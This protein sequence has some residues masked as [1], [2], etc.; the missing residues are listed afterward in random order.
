MDVED[1]VMISIDDHTVEPPDMFERTMPAK[2]R[3]RAPRLVRDE[4]GHDRWL[5][6]GNPVG[7]P[8]VSAVVSWP[9]EEWGFDPT[10]L[11]EMRPGC[12][13]VELRVAD[14]DA[15][16]VLAAM[17]FPT[18]LGFAGTHVAKLPDQELSAAA[19]SAYNDWAIDELAGEHPGR[20]IPLSIV[21]YYDMDR[22]VTEVR[23]VAERGCLAVSLPETP[24]G[25]GLPSFGSGHFDPLFKA[26]SDAGMVICLHV[27]IAFGLL[28]RPEESLPDDTIIIAP[29]LS[30]ITATDLFLSGVLRRFP[31]LR[32]AL[33]EGGI[34]WV[35]FFLDK[36][37]RHVVNQSW[38]KLDRLPPGMTP[39][40]VWRKNFMACFIT[41]PSAL[42]LR[43][44]IGVETISWE[45]DYP[46]SDTTWPR[47]P[48][49]LHAELEAARCSDEEID[50]ITWGNVARFFRFD[51]FAHIPK[52]EATVGALRRRAAAAEVDTTE[53]S[54]EEYRRRYELAHA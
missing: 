10:T 24:Y 17:N 51:P 40:E 16:G 14:M 45:C 43:D 18:A 38:T 22:A 52:K 49:V 37:D 3:D 47:S 1:M 44:R 53:T 15:N 32:F 20:F 46:H 36:I 30:T 6:Q 48:E 54:K 9:K 19:I 5:F 34:G 28:A 27:A 21:P 29:Q 2:Y 7:M 12:Y 8:G 31:D 42:R 23:R 25:L 26:I 41:D 11:A 4:Q 35:P 39:S 50:M 33:S 13:D